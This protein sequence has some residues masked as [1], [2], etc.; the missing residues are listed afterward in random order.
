MN[1]PPDDILA[2]A[3]GEHVEP[4]APTALERALVPLSDAARAAIAELNIQ[5]L[6]EA[7]PAHRAQVVRLRGVLARIARD[8]QTYV[9]AIDMA[10]R[11][12][13][14]RSGADQLPFDGGHVRVQRRRG[15]WVVDVPALQKALAELAKADGG[16]VSQAD[17][18]SIFTT[19]VETSA[20]NGRLNYI[21]EHRGDDVR[22]VVDA[23]RRFVE[24][25]ISTAR[26]EY[27]EGQ[28]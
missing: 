14:E 25:P 28:R 24:P 9:D 21:A 20:H 17:L 22:A 26:V 1:L 12:A 23:H 3:V 18:D 6:H 13:T 16:L 27:V 8:C 4:S 11:V 10:F 15:E 5:P 19:K 7:S 2:A